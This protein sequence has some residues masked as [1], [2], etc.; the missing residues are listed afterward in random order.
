MKKSD[1]YEIAIK[2]IGVYLLMVNGFGYYSNIL[3]PITTFASVSFSE[4]FSNQPDLK[5]FAVIS[6][7]NMILA[8]SLSLIFIFR[9]RAIVRIICSATD[10]EES[11]KLAMDKRSVFEIAILL[12]G[13]I[14]LLW[15]L[16]EFSFQLTNQIIYLRE[17]GDKDIPGWHT[18]MDTSF[19]I[20]NGIKI[21]LALFAIVSAKSLAAYFGRE[22]QSNTQRN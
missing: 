20:T 5:L 7:I 17:V 16:P 12:T 13:F 9:S 6:L 1:I 11:A 10:Y 4:E 8:I 21:I 19:M 15:T 14:L 22:K 3:L 18:S 2:I